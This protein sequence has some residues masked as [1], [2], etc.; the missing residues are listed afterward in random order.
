GAVRPQGVPGDH[1]YVASLRGTGAHSG[2]E[3]GAGKEID[4]A[5]AHRDVG[6]PSGPVRM[7]EDPAARHLQRARKLEADGA[8]VGAAG[9]VRAQRGVH[10]VEMAADDADAAR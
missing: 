10:G 8:A 4:A 2:N 9:V 6:T 3:L 7:A 5:G 1:G